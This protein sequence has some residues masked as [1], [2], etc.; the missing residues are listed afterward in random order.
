MTIPDLDRDTLQAKNRQWWDAN[1]MC[2]DW[3]KTLRAEPGTREFFEEIDERFFRAHA[4]FGHPDYPAEP[5][6]NR[7]LNYAARR[8]QMA[9]EIGCGMGSVAAVMAQQGL[10]VTALD[11]SMTAVQMTRRRFELMG[12]EGNILQADGEQLPFPDRTFDLVWSWGVIHHS[13]NTARIVEEI[14]RVLKP[15]GEAKVMVYHRHS[16]RNWITAGLHRGLLRGEFL[17]KR[18]DDILREVTDGF[19]ARHLTKEQARDLFARFEIQEIVLTDYADLSYIPGNVQINR[20]LV[21]R[22]VPRRWKK[23][24]DNWLIARFGWF[25]YLEARRPAQG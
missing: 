14:Y 3:Q 2:Y 23:R 19:I 21:G 8:G 18:Y 12:L 24:W 7:Q 15:G 17:Y 13:A 9:L 16:L 22:I 10:R 5:A 20:Y 25:L 4:E 6:F 11:L 1:P